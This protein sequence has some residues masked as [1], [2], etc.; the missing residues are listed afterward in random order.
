M[1]SNEFDFSFPDVEINVYEYDEFSDQF[2][3]GYPIHP[4]IIMLGIH[5]AII[6]LSSILI[7]FS[8]TLRSVEERKLPTTCNISNNYPQSIQQ[9][10]S[11]ITKYAEK[12][13]LPA[14]LIAAVIWQESGGNPNAYS[15]SGAVGLMQIM[16][17]DGLAASFM[18]INGPC[19][20][21]RPTMDELEDPEFNIS[22]GTYM[23]ADLIIQ[24][25]DYREALKSYGPM[26]IGYS[27]A[28][29]VLGI[30]TQFKNDVQ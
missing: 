12:K 21:N 20:S 1:P 22:Y 2:Q 27:Y 29:Q 15:N 17:R 6:S 11:I 5:I 16:P 19:F 7:R 3:S 24:K 10:C 26:D 23:L 4:L 14:D 8:A 13:E 9:W 18:C 30:F 25:G 28:D